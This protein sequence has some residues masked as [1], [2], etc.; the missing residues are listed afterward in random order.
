MDRSRRSRPTAEL[1]RR[2]GAQSR[3]TKSPAARK[4]SERPGCV[5]VGVGMTQPREMSSPR[6]LSNGRGPLLN[7]YSAK[8]QKKCK[9]SPCAASTR[10]ADAAGVHVLRRTAAG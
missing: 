8:G 2:A 3:W 1:E 10:T 5:G 9:I 4:V 7:Y 6:I